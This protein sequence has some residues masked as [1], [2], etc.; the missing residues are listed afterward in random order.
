[1]A[2]YY[3]HGKTWT[4]AYDGR[5][6]GKPRGRRAYIYG[7]RTE[8][9]A[10]QA[11]DQKTLQEQL[12]KADLLTPD[13]QGARAAAAAE[14]PI[15]KHLEEFE[16]AI[17]AKGRTAMHARQQANHVRRLL[18][19]ASIDKCSDLDAEQIQSAAKRLID[20]RGL[21][22]RTAN[23]AVKAARQFST[24]CSIRGYTRGDLLHRR[25]KTYNEEVDCRRRRRALSVEEFQW[26]IKSLNEGHDHG[27]RMGINRADRAML[28]QVA[29][30]TGF[31]ESAMLSLTPRSFHVDPRLVRP[32]V[33]LAASENK[34]RK[35]REQPI[36]RDLA[37]NIHEWLKGRPA[38]QPV[39]QPTPH[40][41]MGLRYRRDLEEARAAWIAAAGDD[42]REAKR[43]RES[44]F[45]EY[46][47]DDGRGLVWCDFH[48][49]RHTGITW[50]ARGSDLR[51]AQ[52]WADHSTPVLTAR[53][54]HMDLTD[55]AKVL[56]ALPGPIEAG[57]Q[58][59]NKRTERRE[60]AS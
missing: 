8:K 10:R 19:L 12:V 57:E 45:L 46:V 1:M 20:E 22:P 15:E 30:G 32:F 11:C 51:A 29:I 47:Y 38:E 31:R 54:R 40:A 21:A 4:V 36:R 43:R 37:T 3:P 48:G 50:V 44:T 55:E 17:V 35:G 60:R 39:W 27:N 42:E 59:Q 7:I 23:A 26:L 28:Y 18:E 2:T 58:Q 41:D 49:L 6:A 34:K 16:G 5:L 13:P 52:I 9:L 33:A 25:L 56:E 53:Y 14:V 24:W